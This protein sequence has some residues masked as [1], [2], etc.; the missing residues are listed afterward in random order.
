MN[1]RSRNKVSAA[2]NMSSLTDIIFLL[3]IFFMLT[4]TLVNP[5]AL[6]LLLPSSDNK[7]KAKM[8][9]TVSIDKELNYY[10]G[11]DRVALSQLSGILTKELKGTPDATVVLSAEQSV[12]IQN[13]VQVMNIAND[14]KIK[15]I[16]A[17]QPKK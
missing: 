6:K 14:L 9:L 5:N 11:K 10:V 4:S 16:L 1:L 12:P 17:T 3:L 8:N 2:F 15:M 13:V 7:T